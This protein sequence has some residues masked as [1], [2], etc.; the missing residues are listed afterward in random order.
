MPASVKQ[1]CVG[2]ETIVNPKEEVQCMVNVTKCAFKC[3]QFQTVSTSADSFFTHARHLRRKNTGKLFQ[4]QIKHI[5]HVVG[6]A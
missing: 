4:G 3:Q 5:R 1:N 2:F 6:Y